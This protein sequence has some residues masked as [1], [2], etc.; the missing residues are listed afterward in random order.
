MTYKMKKVVSVVLKTIEE[1]K[2]M[3]REGEINQHQTSEDGEMSSFS[4]PWGTGE[5]PPE[6]HKGF[7]CLDH[8]EEFL[9]VD[10]PHPISKQQYEMIKIFFKEKEEGKTT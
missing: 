3:V 7:H 9:V 5:D 6:V 1:F 8:G 4:C 10:H 2:N